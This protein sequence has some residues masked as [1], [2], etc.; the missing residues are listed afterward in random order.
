[1]NAATLTKA[2]AIAGASVRVRAGEGAA[3]LVAALDAGLPD[4]CVRIAAAHAETA[5]LG[6]MFGVITVEHA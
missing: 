4:N 6:A 1:M 3:V 2:G 5:N